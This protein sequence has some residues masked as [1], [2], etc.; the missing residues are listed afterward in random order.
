MKENL[1]LNL[2]HTFYSSKSFEKKSKNY[3]T[4]LK[5]TKSILNNCL[6]YKNYIKNYRKYTEVLSFKTPKL[7]KY[8]ILNKRSLSLLPISKTST[9]KEEEEKIINKRN[10]HNIISS[11]FSYDNIKSRNK[12]I[13]DFH[14]KIRLNLKVLEAKY[15]KYINKKKKKKTQLYLNFF[16][17]GQKMTQSQI[18][19]IQN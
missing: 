10:K 14:K 11:G 1:K 4:I 13:F 8:P 15:Q 18:L 16:I 9:Y 5:G 12:K 17:N 6:T 3:N 7:T 2:Y 19:K